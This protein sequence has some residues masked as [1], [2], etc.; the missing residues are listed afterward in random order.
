MIGRAEGNDT[1][2]GGRLEEPWGVS[3]FP[4]RADSQQSRSAAVADDSFELMQENMLRN[5]SIHDGLSILP[6]ISVT[7]SIKPPPELPRTN[8]HLRKD[9]F[10]TVGSVVVPEK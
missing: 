7:V 9:S 2:E 8:Q 1:G 10:T 6:M 5:V 4:A 3:S